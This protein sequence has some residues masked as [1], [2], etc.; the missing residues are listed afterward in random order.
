MVYI[1]LTTVGLSASPF[2]WRHGRGNLAIAD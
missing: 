2:N 1:M